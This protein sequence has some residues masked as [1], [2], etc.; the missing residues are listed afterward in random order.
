MSDHPT[1]FYFHRRIKVRGRIETAEH[2]RLVIT[3]D[4]PAQISSN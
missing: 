1:P 3:V 2:G 4:D